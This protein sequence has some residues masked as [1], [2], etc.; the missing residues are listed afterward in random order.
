MNSSSDPPSLPLNRAKNITG[1]F[2]A[3][4]HKLKLSQF[5]QQLSVTSQNV[6]IAGV[7]VYYSPRPASSVAYGVTRQFLHKVL[8]FQTTGGMFSYDLRYQGNTFW[9]ALDNPTYVGNIGP[10]KLQNGI[11]SLIGGTVRTVQYQD[12]LVIVRDDGMIPKRFYVDQTGA[13]Y[14]YQLGITTPATPTTA[15][16]GAGNPNGTYTYVIT[17]QDEKN[18]ESSPSSASTPLAAA[19]Q[20]ITVTF[21]WGTDPQVKAV[22]IYRITSGGSIYYR[23]TQITNTATTSYTDNTSDAS[24]NATGAIQAP[25]FGQN[26][27]PLRA[28]LGCIYANRLVLNNRDIYDHPTNVASVSQVQV[29]NTTG[30][31]QFSS[32]QSST[33]LT[34]GITLTIGTDPSDEVTGV[35]AVGSLLGVWKRKTYHHVYGQDITSFTV[36]HIHDKGCVATDSIA[37]G[38]SYIVWL[39]DDGLYAIGGLISESVVPGT[40]SPAC[41]SREINN[42]FTGYTEGSVLS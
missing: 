12:E 14:L 23:V 21:T 2:P 18:R 20:Q 36:R 31:T 7:A 10:T 13:M 41:I 25:A 5:L 22:N 27:P 26:D 11:G 35:A 3:R 16:G 9:V 17:Y 29:S 37:R 8:V 6:G 28:S 1:F 4:Y 38:G 33:T 39:S 34:D 30:I 40:Y 24:L 42:Y 15:T 32:V 19:N